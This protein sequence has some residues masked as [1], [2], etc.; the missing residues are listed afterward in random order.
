ML[1][2]RLNWLLI[3]TAFC[4]LALGGDNRIIAQ[5]FTLEVDSFTFTALDEQAEPA[6][7]EAAVEAEACE[8]EGGE[9]CDKEACD[10]STCEESACDKIEGEAKDRDGSTDIDST[11]NVTAT[12][13]QT[14]VIKVHV[15]DLPET[16]LRT[17][18]L[19]AGGE[20]LAAC[21]EG[22]SGDVR[23]FSA[24]GDLIDSWELPYAPEAINTGSDGNVYVAGSGKFSRYTIEGELIGEGKHPFG[25]PTEEMLEKARKDVIASHKQQLTWM[26]QQFEEL[27]S[28]VEKFEAKVKAEKEVAH[29]TE[30]DSDPSA[31]EAEE[32]VEESDE[33]EEEHEEEESQ[34]DEEASEQQVV[35][36]DNLADD[37][38]IQVIESGDNTF[39]LIGSTGFVI[40][41][42]TEDKTQYEAILDLLISQRDSYQQMVENQGDEELTEEQIEDKIKQSLLYKMK[43][44][45]ISEADGEV[46]LAT[47]AQQGYGFSVWRTNRHFDSAELIVKQLSGCCGQMDVQACCDGVFVAENSRH[48]VRRFD[49][50]GDEVCSWGSGNREG[51]RGFGGCCNPMNVAFGPDQTVYTAES[52]TG[53]IKRFTNEG[54]LIELVGKAD[55]VPGCKKVSIAIGP[56]G[57]R[58][59]MLDITRNHIVM[60]ERPADGEVVAYSEENSPESGFVTSFSGQDANEIEVDT[61]EAFFRSLGRAMA[62]NN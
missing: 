54:E 21:G 59:Y 29:Q 3:A 58:V 41:E 37:P 50:T 19:T 32:S 17:F 57:D 27:E 56:N 40:P 31:E 35:I 1:F 25:D 62:K 47:G 13:H 16:S 12:H 42:P 48:K 2:E 10:E 24:T 36:Y 49:R 23:R 7:T 61:F 44:A 11:E 45:S 4:F 6:E 39:I 28:S 8:S 26:T 5:E 9:G 52:E 30:T 34:T 15:G 18:C 33:Q 55:L 38:D 43:V 60:L 46:F 22:E 53:R 51:L 20:I 14:K